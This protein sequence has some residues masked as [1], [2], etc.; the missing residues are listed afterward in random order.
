MDAL[1]S[2]NDESDQGRNLAANG[3]VELEFFNETKLDPDDV[4]EPQVSID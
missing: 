2:K 4:L 1:S 3:I